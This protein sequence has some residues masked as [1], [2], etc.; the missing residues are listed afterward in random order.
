MAL[1]TGRTGTDMDDANYILRQFLRQL[2][3][4]FDNKPPLPGAEAEK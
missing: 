2:N 3:I 1:V 4:T